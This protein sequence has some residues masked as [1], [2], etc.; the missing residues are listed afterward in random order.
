MT[1]FFLDSPRILITH[2]EWD[3]SFGS[4]HP[5]PGIGESWAR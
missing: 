1:T 4:E 3:R 5:S 2:A